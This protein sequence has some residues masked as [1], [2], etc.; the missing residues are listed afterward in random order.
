VE[1]LRTQ[2]GEP[3]DQ[4][5]ADAIAATSG[6]ITIDRREAVKEIGGSVI[7]WRVWAQR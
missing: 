1:L 6:P 3:S 5:L 2:E 4:E 7:A